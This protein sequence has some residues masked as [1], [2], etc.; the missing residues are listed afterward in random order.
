MDLSKHILTYHCLSIFFALTLSQ[1]SSAFADASEVTDYSGTWLAKVRRVGNDTCRK[2]S[3][4]RL[5][6]TI[7]VQQ[8]NDRGKLLGTIRGN[9]K[10][11]TLN[12]RTF[13]R[14]FNLWQNKTYKAGKRGT[15]VLQEGIYIPSISNYHSMKVNF[16]H[17]VNC[18]GGQ[19]Y[20]CHYTYKGSAWR[21][22]NP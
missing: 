20:S 5:N 1:I 14:A 22:S 4:T 9:G 8:V 19:R 11:L 2:N 7:E 6:L 21:K 13:I 10:S 15:C 18:H 16:N 12:G 17:N 3:P